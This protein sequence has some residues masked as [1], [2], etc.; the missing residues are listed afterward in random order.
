MGILKGI[1]VSLLSLLLT[2]SVTAFFSLKTLETI[3]SKEML[4]G[5]LNLASKQ[6]LNAT[7][8]EQYYSY[9]KQLCNFQPNLTF[10]TTQ[11][12]LGENITIS[13]SCQEIV[14]SE[15]YT[16]VINKTIDTVANNLYNKRVNV[17]G[18]LKKVIRGDTKKILSL[19]TK[20]ANVTF[21]KYSNYALILII[22]SVVLLSLLLAYK[23]ILSLAILFLVTSLIFRIKPELI[24]NLT[25]SLVPKTVEG[26]SSLFIEKINEVNKI[27]FV[28]SIALLIDGIA[29]VILSKLLKKRKEKKKEPKMKIKQ[30]SREIRE[31]ELKKMIKEK[32][33][34][35]KRTKK[36]KK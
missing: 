33:K 4:I 31:E 13:I 3:S 17:I 2:L 29:L 24:S 34:T 32:K 23:P 10:N 14:S 25:S 15:D 6:M 16:Y 11:E 5:V 35:K 22:L 19:F 28:L 9:A 8:V 26:L 12:V 1:A 20:D 36:A 7:E 21:K 18:D 27:S 30:A